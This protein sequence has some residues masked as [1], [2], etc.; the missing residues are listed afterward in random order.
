MPPQISRK[1]PLAQMP[2]DVVGEHAQTDVSAD[3]RR[4]PMEDWSNMQIDRLD[5]A[6]SAFYL[7]ETLAGADGGAVVEGRGFKVGA[8]RR[9]ERRRRSRQRL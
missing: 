3:A 4:R 9:G 8:D 5:A 2:L 7:G 6:N 1:L